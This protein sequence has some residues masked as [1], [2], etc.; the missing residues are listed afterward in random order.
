M[1][2]LSDLMGSFKTQR[3]RSAF[4]LPE[5]DL[6]FVLYYLT[7]PPWEL[8]QDFSDKRLTLETFFLL[9]LASVRRRGDRCVRD[10]LSPRWLYDFSPERGYL[11]KTR[12]ATAG[13]RAFSPFVIPDLS[14]FGG[15]G[16]TD[17]SLCP[18][19]AVRLYVTRSNNYRHDRLRLFLSFQRVRTTT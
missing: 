12:V 4:S 11:P 1:G 16:E 6:A 15:A 3:P 18:V 5:W 14:T 7:R 19:R 9:L 10:R 13:E 2:V 8:I 17:V